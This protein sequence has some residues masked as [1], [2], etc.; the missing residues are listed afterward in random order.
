MEGNSYLGLCSYC[1]QMLGIS[2][3]T[4]STMIEVGDP[5][6]FTFEILR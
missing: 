1:F 2:K 5:R 4:E 6:Y 3:D